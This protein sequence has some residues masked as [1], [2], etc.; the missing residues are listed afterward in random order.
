MANASSSQTKLGLI[1]E[2][3]FGTTP[4]TPELTA[5]RFASAQFTLSREELLDPSITGQRDYTYVQL[6]NNSIEGQISGP[7]SHDNYDLLMESALFSSFAANVLKNSNV[8]KSFTIELGQPDVPSYSQ[9]TGCVVNSMTVNAPVDGNAEISFELLALA[10]TLGTATIDTNGT[11]TTQ[12]ARQPF[13]HCGGLISEGGSP[14]AY[15]NG[16]TFTSTNGISPQYYWGGCNTGDLNANRF[17]V[18]GTLDVF[19]ANN[20]LLNKFKNATYSSLSFTLTDNEARTLTFSLPK[21]MYTG[22]DAPRNG[23]GP[24]IISLPFR[25]V[26]DTTAACTLSVTRSA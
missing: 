17:D 21:I 26:Y 24:V 20:T 2:T 6:G 18:T 4:S 22:A 16:V 5:Q 7:L 19:F 23:D 12:A 9:Y 13:T 14:I 25:A 3:T 11:Y 8:R 10:E 1:A 15:V